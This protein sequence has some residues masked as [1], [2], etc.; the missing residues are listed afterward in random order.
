MNKARDYRTLVDSIAVLVGPDDGREARMK[1]LVDAAWDLM[2]DRG[3]S[4]IGFYGKDGERDQ[5]M[6]LERRDKPA[7]SPIGLH[8]ACGRSW[9]SRKALIV[10]DV[11]RL[12]E[13]YIACDPRD[14]SEIV[15]PMF[16]AGGSC[17]GV[18][19]VDSH[20]TGAFN[21]ADAEGLWS[22]CFAA[23]LTTTVQPEIEMV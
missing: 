4:W 6:L 22:A 9:R 12:G 2:S 16:D 7:C 14:R 18:L 10:S 13:G 15:I 19:D 11:A 17:W 8:G 1:A 23:G 20:Q 5:L 3:V 21:S